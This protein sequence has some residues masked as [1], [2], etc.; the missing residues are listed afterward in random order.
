MRPRALAFVAML[1]IVAS[2][3]GPAATPS[4]SGLAPGSGAPTGTQVP[5]G[6]GGSLSFY[7]FADVTMDFHTVDAQ[8]NQL[9]F[10]YLIFD[11][12]VKLD[13]TDPTLQKLVPDLAQTWDV[14][15]DGLTYTMHLRHGVTWQD[16]QQFTADDVV[17]T[18]TWANENSAGYIGYSPAW[19]SLKGGSDL[20]TACKAAPSDTSKCGGTSTFP[21]VKKIDDYTVEFTLGAP[22]FTF[23]RT[24]ADASSVILPKHL[25]VG[26]TLDQI[27]KGDFKTKSPV[28]TGPF[29]LKAIVPDQYVEFDANPNYWNGAPKL[30]KLFYKVLT[31]QTAIAALESGALDIGLAAPTSDQAELAKSA[32]LNVTQVPGPAVFPLLMHDETNADRIAWK[33][34]LN[35][36]LKPLNFDFS[37]VRVRQAVYYAI[38]RRSINTSLLGGANTILWNP[39]AMNN[40]P[41]LN[42][43][44]FNPQKAKDLLAAAV[45]DGKVDLSKH[46]RLMYGTINNSD[47]IAPIVKQQL[48][49]VGF[50]VDLMQVDD[51]TYINLTSDDTQRDKFD[52][53]FNPGGSEGLG[54]NRS[55]IYFKCGTEPPGGY[56]GYY[57]CDLHNLFEK[58]LTLT[59]PTARDALYQQAATIINN[60]VPWLYFWQI[61]EVHA[62]NKKVQGLTIPSFD[63]Y[64]FGDA[65][66][67]SI[68]Q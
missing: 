58:A 5:S 28:G 2:A 50:K 57:N 56:A 30:D 41:G 37:D 53:T 65:Q 39:P 52:M 66:N 43:Y 27:N 44:E 26:Q 8:G 51:N 4:T 10:F 11:P 32:Q 33:T 14:S 9:M 68:G 23:M 60:D 24:M 31:T 19:W 48:E 16:G 45:A 13:L 59:D 20:G 63:R 12:L 25:L 64:A 36:N 35:L 42:Q 54:P 3:C 17:Y 29:S 34:S 47:Q 46:I 21:S 67:W 7:R 62:V 38:D 55:E 61:A 6:T 1:A 18:A 15:T 22:N 49:A 40:Y